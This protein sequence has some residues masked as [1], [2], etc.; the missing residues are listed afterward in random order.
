H[1]VWSAEASC[2]GGTCRDVFYSRQLAPATSV[3]GGSQDGGDFPGVAVLPGGEVVV[4]FHRT[5]GDGD[6]FWTYAE[7]GAQ[8]VRVQSATPGTRDT[9]EYFVSDLAVDP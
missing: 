6:L 9:I 1:L 8:F 3:T 7:S 4:A 5:A 2:G